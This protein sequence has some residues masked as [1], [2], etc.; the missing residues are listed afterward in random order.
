MYKTSASQVTQC[1]YVSLEDLNKE[2]LSHYI[3]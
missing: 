1:R 3:A 2:Y